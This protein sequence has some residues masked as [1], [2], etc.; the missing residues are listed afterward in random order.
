MVQDV[1]SYK[2]N[3]SNSNVKKINGRHVNGDNIF[4]CV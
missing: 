1:S 3:L 4:V 2:S